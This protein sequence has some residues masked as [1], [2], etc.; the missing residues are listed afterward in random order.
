M[1][2]RCPGCE[3]LHVVNAELLAH[4]RGSVKCGRCGQKFDALASLFDEWPEAGAVAPPAGKRY[5]PPVLGSDQDL[6]APFG[7]ASR[8]PPGSDRGR[9][10]W[11]AAL[12]LLTLLTL[13]HAAWAFR[14]ELLAVPAARALFARWHLVSDVPGGVLRDPERIQVVS[15]DLHSHPT[16][17]GMLV[18]SATFVSR[19]HAAQA[20]PELE[21]T[22]LDLDGEAMARRRFKPAEYLPDPT[23]FSG[24]IRPDVHVPVLLEFAS[25]GDQAV[26]FQIAFR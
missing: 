9:A 17:A 13:L 25:P 6:P 3:S 12:S 18:L 4:S 8:E 16:R 14:E 5:R 19:A 26:G 1:Y 15:R 11:L 2:T 10:G 23:A 21:L 20:W 22:L 24:L 7:P